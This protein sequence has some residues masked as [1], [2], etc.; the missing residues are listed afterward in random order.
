MDLH[1]KTLPFI[2]GYAVRVLKT[3]SILALREIE[4]VFNYH[5]TNL[6]KVFVFGVAYNEKESGKI[7]LTGNCGPCITY[8]TNI[9]KAISLEGYLVLVMK[10]A[11]YEDT[12][13][14]IKR[15]LSTY[16]N[17]EI[18]SFDEIDMFYYT[19]SGSGKIEAI[20]SFTS[21]HRVNF[22]LAQIETEEERKNR[23][24]FTKE[25]V[26]KYYQTSNEVEE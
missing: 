7:L 13:F 18:I 5:V 23:V 1:K 12:L 20:S 9:A 25:L 2:P 11:R 14:I 26:A 10:P 4:S 8:R 6:K 15:G 3:P 16:T 21:V 19:R 22:A 24:T 17:I